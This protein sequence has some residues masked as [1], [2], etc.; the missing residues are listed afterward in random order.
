MAAARRGAGLS[1]DNLLALV[2]TFARCA[3]D[4]ATQWRCAN[5]GAARDVA[6]E[7]SRL[8]FD[9][10]LRAVLGAGAT[11]LDERRFLEA[12]AP[13]LASVGWRFLYAR[14][15]LPDAL[16]LSWLAPRRAQHRLAA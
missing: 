5:D 8:T 11:A 12:L 6:P 10:I 13:S 14:I 4:L 15:G 1:S 2:P 9:I 7:M 3:A 16:P